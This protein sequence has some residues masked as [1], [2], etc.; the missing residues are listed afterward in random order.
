MQLN[1]LYTWN[2]YRGSIVFI[3]EEVEAPL[4]SRKH[5]ADVIIDE[6]AASRDD[7]ARYLN[8]ICPIR[9]GIISNAHSDDNVPT[10]DIVDTIKKAINAFGPEER[11]ALHNSA[12]PFKSIV[13]F[14]LIAVVNVCS[15]SLSE[16]TV[17]LILF[18]IGILYDL[19]ESD[20]SLK[21]P[22]TD[23]ILNYTD[24]IKNRVPILSTTKHEAVNNK[25]GQTHTFYINKVSTYIRELMRNPIK[26]SQLSVLPDYTSDELSRLQQAL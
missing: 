10:T 13:E 20:P 22:A 4:Q 1:S 18:I 9:D 23:Y 26:S 25:T 2:Y 15:V 16:E 6:E 3:F 12:N 5:T 11:E 21:I 24:R 8:I 7:I 17:R 19:K 14:I